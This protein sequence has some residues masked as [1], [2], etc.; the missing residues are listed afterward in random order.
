MTTPKHC[1]FIPFFLVCF[2]K[3]EH[4]PTVRKSA[5]L[6][7]SCQMAETLPG[8]NPPNRQK[9]SQMSES[10]PMVESP[11]SGRKPSK[12]QKLSLMA[13]NLPHVRKS[14]NWQKAHYLAANLPHVRKSP[15]WQK[16][17]QLAEHY[18]YYESHSI[19]LYTMIGRSCHVVSFVYSIAKALM[20]PK[21]H[22]S[23]LVL[24]CLG[25]LANSLVLFVSMWFLVSS[26]VPHWLT[27]LL[28]VCLL[29]HTWLCAVH[30][31][32]LYS[33]IGKSSHFVSCNL[34]RYSILVAACILC[35]LRLVHCFG[36]H[37]NCFVLLPV[38][39]VLTS[40]ARDTF[41]VR[42]A[43]VIFQFPL[44]CHYD[45]YILDTIFVKQYCPRSSF[46][47]FFSGVFHAF[48]IFHETVLI[49]C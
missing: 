12:R 1:V 24:L 18:T 4:L 10:P 22:Q 19:I 15:N 31:T 33:M 29:H 14:P 6:E 32:R 5:N 41:W 42:F 35:A 3:A 43:S 47:N 17:H 21:I 34:L 48:H 7:R 13:A 38:A 40:L 26:K 9:T 39:W 20:F 23:T 2:I 11:S 36:L 37:F 16:A 44:S 28:A 45:C 30:A 27:L 8:R 25:S 46:H 49:T